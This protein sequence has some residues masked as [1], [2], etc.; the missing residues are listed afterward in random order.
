MTDM[1]APA[2]HDLLIR[3]S[4]RLEAQTQ[5]SKATLS[6]VAK[7]SAMLAEM[8]EGFV[9]QQRDVREV[10]QRQRD[11][12]LRIATLEQRVDTLQEEADRHRE[13]NEALAN[14]SEKRAKRYAWLA[15]CASPVVGIV[16][17]ALLKWLAAL[18][19]SAP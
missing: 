18:I 2:D 14:E 3:L 15:V 19:V 7:M 6:E 11:D 17:P 8:R 13:V 4:E 12:D 5:V 9:G 1:M 10:Q 16:V